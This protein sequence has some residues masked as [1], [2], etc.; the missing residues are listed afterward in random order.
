MR[1]IS[2]FFWLETDGTG[3]INQAGVDH[4]NNFINALLVAGIRNSGLP[5]HGSTVDQNVF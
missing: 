3:A 5:S 4:Y 1:N 2:N